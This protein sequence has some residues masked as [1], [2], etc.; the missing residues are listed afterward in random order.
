[1]SI[2]IRI[3]A[4][5]ENASGHA[6]PDENGVLVLPHLA[7]ESLA[8]L[9]YLQGRVEAPALCSGLGRCG[10]CRMRFC[11]E[12]PPPLPKEQAVLD[13][14]ALA[15]GWRLG[16]LRM[17][18][19]GLL[20]E[21][22]DFVQLLSFPGKISSRSFFPMLSSGGA[23]AFAAE[24]TEEEK[25]QQRTG[26][27]IDLGTTSLHWQLLDAEGNV[28]VSG[29]QIN[30][31]MGA[32]SDVVSRLAAALR[33]GGLKILSD[34]VRAAVIQIIGSLPFLPAQICLAANSVMTCLFL[35]ENLGEETES[36]Q[37]PCFEL[38][39][40]NVACGDGGAGLPLSSLKFR[41]PKNGTEG[42]PSEIS[43]GYKKA[44]KTDDTQALHLLQGLARAPYSLP[45]H[46]GSIH[47]L[48]GLPS[49]YLPPLL[50]PFVGGDISAGLTALCFG[51]CGVDVRYP[52]LLA[53]L[54][55]NCEFVLGSAPDRFYALSIPMGPSIEGIGLSCGGM[56]GVGSEPGVISC[57]SLGPGGLTADVPEAEAR[58]ISGAG[59]F[60]LLSILL[61]NGIICPD[62]RF[63]LR[64]TGS[65]LADRLRKRLLLSE[66]EACFCFG[67]VRLTSA[68]IE[69]LLKVKAAFSLAYKVLLEQAGV[70]V[71]EL[72]RIFLA[73]AL[74]EHVRPG[75][76]E[77]LG[78]L[79]PGTSVQGVTGLSELGGGESAR[80][81]ALGN[82]SLAGASLLLFSA[83][84]RDFAAR[85][86][87]KAILVSL[88]D[89]ADF[90]ERYLAEMHFVY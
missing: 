2:I 3:C 72:S 40:G 26:L 56:A 69:E 81:F 73:G 75:H 87:E 18:A 10:L 15:A 88:T 14:A 11:T 84:A 71:F 58:A 64:R 53:D 57:F 70:G 76:L 23:S 46:G 68:D 77:M 27:A 17:S 89:R 22:P 79:P 33:P 74:G 5:N 78:F 48:P 52:F 47:H 20:V 28:L 21:L 55:T 85:F 7:G 24:Q 43:E 29:K 38:E 1:M 9:V 80:V 30:P 60:S 82:A 35:G 42:T 65:P 41:E 16:C 12:A 51:K 4:L 67:A 63:N 25:R 50:G 90:M 39:A 13:D 32:G 8:R 44:G 54:G 49:L 86:A 36:E 37:K 62:G 19:P 66:D 31:Q 83:A 61:S 34:L 59:Y 6:L 45:L